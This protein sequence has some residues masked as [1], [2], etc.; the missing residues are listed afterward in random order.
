MQPEQKENREVGCNFWSGCSANHCHWAAGHLIKNECETLFTLGSQQPLL[1]SQIT[2]SLLQLLNY[3]EWRN[4]NDDTNNIHLHD[5]A[6]TMSVNA[7]S[8]ETHVYIFIDRLRFT[9]LI[10]LTALLYLRCSAVRVLKIP[11]FRQLDREWIKQVPLCTNMQIHW[12]RG[13]S[14]STVVLLFWV[15]NIVEEGTKYSQK[16]TS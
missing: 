2:V 15:K 12:H 13:G 11:V 14:S 9:V 6:R 3:F 16:D 1:W 7:T 8:M 4:K 5:A 10:L